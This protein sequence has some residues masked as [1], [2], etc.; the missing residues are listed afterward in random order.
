[1][2]GSVTGPGDAEGPRCV[3]AGQLIRALGDWRGLRP[4]PTSKC[5][6]D[7][8]RAA[9]LSGPHLLSAHGD[10]PCPLFTVSGA[11]PPG[12]TQSQHLFYHNVT[13]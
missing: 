7:P 3:S 4:P 8:K 2:A 10:S 13:V 5:L 11:S 9:Y 12:D 6:C 1:M